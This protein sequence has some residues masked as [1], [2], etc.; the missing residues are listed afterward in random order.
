MTWR[1]T[2]SG[3][4]VTS[5]LRT[6]SRF[7][8]SLPVLILVSTILP[9]TLDAATLQVGPGK[10]YASLQE[11][12]DLVNPGDVVEV[13]GDHTYPGGV[14][15]ERPGLPGSPITI[16]GISINGNRPILSG[17]TNTITFSTPNPNVPDDGANHYILDNFEITA[18][19]FRGIFHQADDLTVRDTLVHDCPAHGIL[20]ADQGSGSATLERVEV[21]H[22][23]NDGSQHQI[24]MAT[25]EVHHPGSVFR[26]VHCY[27]HDG[28]GGNNVKSRA[29]RNEI[30][31]NWIEGAYYHELELIGPDPGGAPDEWSEGLVRE[32]SDVVGNVLVK[33]NDFAV[34]RPGGDGTG[35]SNGRYR[36][37][38]NTIIPGSGVVFRIFDGIQ[39]IEMHGNVLFRA[40]GGAVNVTRTVEA[41][42]TDGEQ[43]VGT[44]NWV[45]TGSTNIPS[46]W[47][48][49]LTGS[50]PGFSDLPANDLLPAPGSPLL[51]HAEADLPTHPDFPFPEPLPVPRTHP[52][53]HSVPDPGDPLPRPFDC[54]LD[55]GAL[56]RPIS[57]SV[58][59]FLTLASDGTLTWDAVPSA[60]AYDVVKGDLM[61]L[62]AGNGDFTGSLLDCLVNDGSSPATSDSNMPLA[63]E[64][65][66]YLVRA[67]APTEG[68]Y[69]CG[70]AGQPVSRDTHI[71]ASLNACP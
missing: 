61:L 32:D 13:D 31:Y 58:V 8:F 71:A 27:I 52:P 7:R 53:G 47:T 50:D 44:D 10:T 62:R 63:G 6:P 4:I 21:Y 20:G 59:A 36:F 18:G 28:N 37:V 42:W 9:L 54:R 35:Q 3:M 39:S 49:T 68:S 1:Y 43:M 40:G 16:R 22:C 65:W 19:S 15:F 5:F 11:V 25:D 29:E 17:G 24:Y 38:N 51:D 46:G 67:A 26:M 34:I 12:V 2:D 60:T 66:Y 23:G 70:C 48:G 33:R 45:T 14:I 57:P 55:I 69:D 41:E 64:G 30:Y 56:E